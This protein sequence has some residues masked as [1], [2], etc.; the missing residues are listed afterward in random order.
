[1][2][3]SRNKREKEEYTKGDKTKPGHLVIEKDEKR[4]EEEKGEN[5]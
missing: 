1:M 4:R 5:R 3:E 2:I